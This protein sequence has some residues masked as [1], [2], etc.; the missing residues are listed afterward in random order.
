[1]RSLIVTSVIICSVLCLSE[2]LSDDPDTTESFTA[3][4]IATALL[5][6]YEMP[7]D[8]I[9]SLTQREA[10]SVVAIVESR[11][12]DYLSFSNLTSI[13]KDVAKE[14]A[15][16]RGGIDFFGLT[17][18]D[19][20]VAREL[21]KFRGTRIYLNSLNSIDK[22]VAK[23]LAKFKAELFLRTTLP[24]EID[25]AQEFTRFE[26][27]LL[28]I[29]G[30]QMGDKITAEWAKFD[31]RYLRLS[32][33]PSISKN[34]AQELATF[35]GKH[36]ALYGLSS[37]TEEIAKELAKF[38]GWTLLLKSV[39]SIDEESLAYLNSN[40]AIRLPEQYRD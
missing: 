39:S 35:K 24:I 18:I 28:S 1:M 7:T 11:G 30:K 26:G 6:R 37:I 12:G 17:S 38:K 8:R 36:L 21:A 20:E 2:G 16:F 27:T 34:A 9:K 3:E 10:A 23:E 4:Q 40:P 22:E 13:N 33:S 19:K 25:V 29:G 32:C 14:L 31:G 15:K 5:K